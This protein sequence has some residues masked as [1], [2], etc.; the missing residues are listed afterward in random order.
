MIIILAL[1][2][3]TA[4]ISSPALAAD[5]SKTF[6]LRQKSRKR[7]SLLKSKFV[8]LEEDSSPLIDSGSSSSSF[9]SEAPVTKTDTNGLTNF[10]NKLVKKK[11]IA[12]KAPVIVSKAPVIVSKAKQS[13]NSRAKGSGSSNGGSGGVASGSAKGAGHST[14]YGNG[15]GSGGSGADANKTII[16]QNIFDESEWEGFAVDKEIELEESLGVNAKLLR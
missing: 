4:S 9:A 13:T 11:V 8:Y 5:A 2:L 6:V 1:V 12:S 3:I 14:G 16:S 15:K 7:T 10:S